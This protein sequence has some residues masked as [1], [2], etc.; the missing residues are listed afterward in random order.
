MKEKGKPSTTKKKKII[1]KKNKYLPHIKEKGK[2]TTKQETMYM[3]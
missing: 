2:P 1:R 3:T